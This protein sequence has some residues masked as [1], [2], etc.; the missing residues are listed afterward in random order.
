LESVELLKQDLAIEPD[1]QNFIGFVLESVSRLGGDIFAATIVLLNLMQNLRDAGAA[2]GNLMPVSLVLQG[3]H[4]LTLWGGQ[5]AKIMDFACLPHQEE[6]AQ[7]RLYLQN[8]TALTAPDILLLRNAQMA[9]HLDEVRARTEKEIESLQQA[10]EKRQ[11]ELHESMRQAETDPLTSLL[12]RR[13][14]DDRLARAFHHTMRQKNAPLSLALFDLDHFKEINDK[15]GHQFGD[16]HLN[17]M[18][19]ILRN[20]IR[21]DVDFAFR[22]GGDEFAMVIFADY[23]LACDKARQVLQ[24]MDNKVSIG[25]TAIG[26]ETPDSLTLEEFFRRADSALYEAKNQGRGRAV[27]DVCHLANN[28]DCLSPCPKVTVYANG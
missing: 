26:P 24:L 10:V 27:V 6:V 23:P 22:F 25:I 1:L 20:V 3:H 11:S 28:V 8:S 19:H 4:L 21:E 7:L 9:R 13:A 5:S 16:A 17:K 18:A 12:N 15:F 14:F 2:K